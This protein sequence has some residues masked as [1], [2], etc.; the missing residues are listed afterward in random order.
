MRTLKIGRKPDNDIVIVDVSKTVSGYHAVLTLLDN[1]EISICD[2]S[3][4]G[5]RVNGHIIPK[6]EAVTVSRVDNI[7]FALSSRFDWSS[8]EI[9]PVVSTPREPKEDPVIKNPTRKKAK[10]SMFIVLGVVLLLGL[11][12]F[13]KSIR[14]NTDSTILQKKDTITVENKDI[15]TLYTEKKSAVF[16]VYTENKKSKFQ[17]TGFFISASGIA[18]SNFHVFKGTTKGLEVIE[19]LNGKFKI[20]SVIAQS[21]ESDYIVFQVDGKGQ[22]FN[23]IEI[24]ECL[25]RIGENV[26]AIGN[27]EGLEH[28]LSTG[29]ISSLRENDSVIQTTAEIA[30]GSSGGP[31]FNSKGE[32]IGITTAGMGDANLNFAVSLVGLDLEKYIRSN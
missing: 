9:D 28:T 6:N 5:T 24:A 27:P 26:F 7:V 32:V 10:S 29:I 3:R 2:I 18:V 30:H 20:K 8:V 19:T 4:N 17:G 31:L 13:I 21:K 23:Y 25:P 15:S 22:K 1:G 12:V 16:V 14:S 11:T